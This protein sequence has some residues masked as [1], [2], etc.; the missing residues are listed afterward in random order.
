MYLT[1]QKLVCDTNLNLDKQ[2]VP[3][4]TPLTVRGVWMEKNGELIIVFE[5]FPTYIIPLTC[6]FKPMDKDK[7][8]PDYIINTPNKRY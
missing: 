5:D 1:G 3:P 6:N 4:Y 2:V 8:T 7:D